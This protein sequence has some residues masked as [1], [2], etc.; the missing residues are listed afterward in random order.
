VG[1]NFLYDCVCAKMPATR[2]SPVLQCL[3]GGPVFGS[4]VGPRFGPMF[5]AKI[6]GQKNESNS[7]DSHLCPT[8]WGS[9]VGPFL[10]PQS[11]PRMRPI[12]GVLLEPNSRH[13]PEIL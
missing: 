2:H 4:G 1:N 11:G 6:V 5:E 12:F 8:V 10:G 7:Q 3:L 13:I 9:N